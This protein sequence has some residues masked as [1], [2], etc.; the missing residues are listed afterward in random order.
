MAEIA[1][2]KGIVYNQEK[3]GDLADLVAPP[4]DVVSP[5]EQAAFHASSPY[6]VMNIDLGASLPGDHHPHDW[7]TRAA[8][9]YNRWL[10][11]GVLVRHREPAMYGI[12]TD[13]TDP[14][15]RTRKTRHG[16]VCLLRL[17]EFGQGA[18]V[19][20]HERTFSYHR[21]ERI[22]H[23]EHVQAHL[24]Q[25]FAVFPDENR[26]ALNI[27]TQGRPEQP[28]VDFTDHNGQGHR[29]W[30]VWDREIIRTLSL[31]MREK[32]LYIA[33]GH[34][35]YE[36]ALHY[37]RAGIERG[38][39]IGPQ[40]PLNYIMVYLCAI[41]DP[42]LVILP[43]H[44]LL[45]RTLKLNREELE[46]SLS[47]YFN[48]QTFTFNSLDEGAARQAF[49]QRLKEDSSRGSVLG[50]YTHLAKTYYLLEKRPEA[51]NGAFLSSWPEPLRK[52][53]T[54]VLT[55]LVFQN[56]LG[57][58]EACLDDATRISYTSQ[59]AE[60]IR[61]VNEGQAELAAILNPTR[62]E[63][64]QDVAEAGLVMPRKSTFFYPKVLT[65]LVFN[66]VNPFEEVEPAA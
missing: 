55:G 25:I 8:F 29:M 34:H 56:V 31:L 15:T 24:S 3:S 64:V 44:R 14:T 66:P 37:R 23:L 11:E 51:D 20:P 6:N 46:N 49:L 9:E 45:C 30:P 39:Q 21:A 52:L 32:T 33:D 50:L 12:E 65:G 22:H 61:R 40:S 35:R 59:A 58:T 42:G 13:F 27:L 62:M 57:M 38:L 5:E 60:A 4:Y 10:A 43:S 18:K 16:F 17:E 36:T 41:T 26:Q 54:V 63:Q 2:L 19:R 28:L 53:D 7:H 47:K 1:P 48:I